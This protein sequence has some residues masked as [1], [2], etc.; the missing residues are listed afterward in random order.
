MYESCGYIQKSER[1]LVCGKK[2]LSGNS[3]CVHGAAAGLWQCN[4]VS[5]VIGARYGLRFYRMDDSTVGLLLESMNSGGLLD[6]V[7]G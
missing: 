2:Y 3:C 6:K 4:S 1:V 5:L 7:V